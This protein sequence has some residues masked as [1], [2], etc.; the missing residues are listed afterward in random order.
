MNDEQLAYSLAKMKEYGLVTSG[1]AETKGIG[2][3]TEERWQSLFATL[4]EAGVFK[5][6]IDYQK[7]FTLDFINKGIAGK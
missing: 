3:M 1:E 2:T 5:S 4:A 7:A 6:D